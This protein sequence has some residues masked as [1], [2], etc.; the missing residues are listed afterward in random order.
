MREQEKPFNIKV[1][2]YHRVVPG[3]TK[4]YNHWHHVTIAKFRKQLKLID[5]LGFTPITFTDY[6]LYRE[7]KLT[8]PSKP[9]I[10]TFDD[11]YEDT[12]ENAIP[13]MMEMG[14]KGVIYVMG[15][16]KLKRASWEEKDKD[17]ICTLMTN[18]QIKAA[19]KMG[20][21]IGS[22]SMHHEVLS[23]L[24]DHEARKS[25]QKSKEE[26][27]SILNEPIHSFAYPYGRFDQRTKQMVADSGYL[28]ACGV[29]TGSPKFGK[30]IYDIRRLSIGQHTS[31]QSFAIKLITPY[32]YLEWIYHLLKSK[33]GRKKDEPIFTERP[34]NLDRNGEKEY[35]EKLHKKNE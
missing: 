20:F 16:R 12:Y 22:H 23:D 15:N 33:K 28:F 4:K 8:L 7:D 30:T 1:L 24:T 18:K 25:I 5:K 9:I 3:L 19:K 11:G 6:Q 27:E 14:M 13:I 17:D 10:I 21:E 26:I 34:T 31:I 35:S 2:M 32:Q 29:Y